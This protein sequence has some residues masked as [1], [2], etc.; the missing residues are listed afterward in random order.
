MMDTQ[1]NAIELLKRIADCL[2]KEVESWT[3]NVHA[4]HKARVDEAEAVRKAEEKSR[5][6]ALKQL[7]K[8]KKQAEALAKKQEK[9]ETARVAKEGDVKGEAGRDGSGDDDEEARKRK[10]RRRRE[11]ETEVTEE[12]PPVIQAM[13]KFSFGAMT[14]VTDIENFVKVVTNR[15]GEACCAR[16][17]RGSFKK[18][19]SAAWFAL[20]WDWQRFQCVFL[21]LTETHSETHTYY[22]DF[23]SSSFYFYGCTMWFDGDGNCSKFSWICVFVNCVYWVCAPCATLSEEHG[24]SG[25]ECNTKQKVIVSEGSSFSAECC[26]WFDNP[27]CNEPRVQSTVAGPADLLAMDQLLSA[28]FEENMKAEQKTIITAAVLDRMHLASW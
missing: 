21:K 3:G 14:Q 18:V 25:T 28:G 5:K 26:K 11:G 2:T 13:F 1:K 4:L 20:Y 7:E 12:D 15:P 17:R 27:A 19:L 24:L 23:M 6:A 8:E 9:Q 16:L 22:L 10:R